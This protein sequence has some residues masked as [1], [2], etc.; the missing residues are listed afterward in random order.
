MAIK[1]VTKFTKC[2][3]MWNLVVKIQVGN[4]VLAAI[5]CDAR[6]RQKIA[7]QAIAANII[8]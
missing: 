3:A 7:S 2:F 8:L 4:E 6:N 1:N 5:A